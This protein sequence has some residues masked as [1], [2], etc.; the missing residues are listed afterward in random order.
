MHMPT[1]FDM[2]AMQYQACEIGQ[3]NA[4]SYGNLWRGKQQPHATTACTS[5]E[6]PWCWFSFN[7]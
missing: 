3:Y 6:T 5:R 1:A 4:H 2:S 7:G